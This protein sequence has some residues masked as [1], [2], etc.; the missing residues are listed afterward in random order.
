MRIAL[1]IAIAFTAL[2]ASAQQARIKIDTDRKIGEVHP[3][4]FGNFAEHLGRCI[5]GGIFEE[6]SPLSDSEGYR[7]D[8]MKAVKS[9]DVT[10]LRWPGGNFVSGYD[11][12]TA[13]APANSARSAP[14]A[15]GATPSPI[16]SAPT[17]SCA[18]ARRSA[19]SPTSASTPDSAPSR[20][21]ASGSSTPT[22]RATPT[23]PQQRRKNGRD[24][25]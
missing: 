8:V 25:P 22:N 17:S 6:G 4:I 3:H 20:K 21:P 10:L 13:S 23:G 18:T 16:A 12:R 5:Y 1:V 9:L 24:K 7:N 15:P 14:K 2:T 11:W 19:S